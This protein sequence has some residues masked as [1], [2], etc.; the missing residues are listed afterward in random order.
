MKSEIHII[1][2]NGPFT[3]G[4]SANKYRATPEH[5]ERNKR[6]IKIQKERD[7]R[8]RAEAERKNNQSGDAE[9]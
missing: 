7:A 4:G 5:I 2:I 9:S 6:E 3:Q 1:I 8:A